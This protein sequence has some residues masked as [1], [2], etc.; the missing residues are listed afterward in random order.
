MKHTKTLRTICFEDL[1]HDSHLIDYVDEN[2]IILDSMDYSG[3]P[4][5][6]TIKINS[7]MMAFCVDCLSQRMRKKIPDR[8]HD[9]GLIF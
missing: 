5:Y 7:F 3:I 1:K 4:L 6:E 8:F 2:I 9:W